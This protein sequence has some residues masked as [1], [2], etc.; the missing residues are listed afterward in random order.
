VVEI[1]PE[2]MASRD[3][4]CKAWACGAWA[5]VVIGWKTRDTVEAIVGAVTGSLQRPEILV[6]GRY[7]GRELE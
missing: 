4:S 2:A 6:V 3:W 1:P 5:G 7:R